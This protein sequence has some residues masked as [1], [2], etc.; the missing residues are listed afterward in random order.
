M[1]D[2]E[3]LLIGLEPSIQPYEKACAAL[4]GFAN[5]LLAKCRL[6]DWDGGY[7]GAV[8]DIYFI[9]PAPEVLRA[10]GRA[11][12]ARAGA[13]LSAQG[14]RLRIFTEVVFAHWPDHEDRLRLQAFLESLAAIFSVTVTEIDYEELPR[15]AQESYCGRLFRASGITRFTAIEAVLSA[16]QPLPGR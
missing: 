6:Q 1:H 15:M 14:G 11:M 13:L 10:E 5:V 9:F 16:R 3:Q 7:A 8:D 12:A 4:K 2:R